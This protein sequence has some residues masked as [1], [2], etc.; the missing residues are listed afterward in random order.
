MGGHWRPAGACSGA[1]SGAGSI[2]RRTPWRSRVG[3]GPSACSAPLPRAY[4]TE[5]SGAPGMVPCTLPSHRA[6][7]ARALGAPLCQTPSVA[8]ACSLARA[9]APR[10][11]R[12]GPW[13]AAGAPGIAPRS[14][15]PRPRPLAVVPTMGPAR[16]AALALAPAPPRRVA[17]VV[18]HLQRGAA[19]PPV[20]AATLRL[21]PLRA[22]A[23]GALGPAR[24]LTGWPAR[25][26]LAPPCRAGVRRA[27]R[28]GGRP[29]PGLFRPPPLAPQAA[30][31][32]A[33]SPWRTTSRAT[34][35]PGRPRLAAPC[36]P[37][38]SPW[39]Y[40]GPRSGARPSGGGRWP[41][42][43][44]VPTPTPPSTSCWLRLAALLLGQWPPALQPAVGNLVYLDLSDDEA[45]AIRSMRLGSLE[46]L[47]VL[48]PPHGALACVPGNSVSMHH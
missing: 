7:V 12:L 30:A 14:L 19:W 16:P 13:P 38:T 1:P 26:G 22:A 20:A 33:G 24:P 17:P 23:G 5:P 48:P 44:L 2:A 10:G 11:V 8:P 31:R 32:A 6:D 36:P 18:G 25:D 9:S 27:P 45:R 47:R 35:C 15:P 21:A 42:C 34:R 29:R 40:M 3:F 43:R 28:A 39:N 41:R 46:P 4:S 37:S